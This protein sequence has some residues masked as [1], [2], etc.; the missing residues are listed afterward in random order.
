MAARSIAESGVEPTGCRVGCKMADTSVGTLACRHGLTGAP[1]G[2]PE[3]WDA[4]GQVHLLCGVF[5]SQ[6][7]DWPVATPRAARIYCRPQLLAKAAIAASRVAFSA[8]AHS[9]RRQ[10]PLH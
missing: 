9:L 3:A 8:A 4:A 2:D 6:R 10:S 1:N 5:S 7:A